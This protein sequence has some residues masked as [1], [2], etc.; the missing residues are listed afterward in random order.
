VQEVWQGQGDWGLNE[1]G[2]RQAGLLAEHFSDGFP[3]VI[4]SPLSRAR[5]TASMLN[6]AEPDLDD[7][8]MEIDMGSWEGLTHEEVTEQYGELLDRMFKEG[9]DT[10]RGGDGENWEDLTH[11]VGSAFD[12]IVSQRSVGHLALVSHG[13]ALRALVLRLVGG[14]WERARRT[15][16]LP[17]TGYG[18]LISRG[19]RWWIADY[20]LAPHL[21]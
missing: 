11:R 8:L 14:G 1:S 12:A 10:R 6:G 19:D 13:S 5:Q 21:E 7:R 15:G 16:I 3:A 9:E 4:S 20:G 2:R 17:N 18:R